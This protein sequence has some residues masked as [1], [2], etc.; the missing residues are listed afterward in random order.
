[1]VEWHA[2]SQQLRRGW[3][4][5]VSFCSLHP[6][7]LGQ[8]RTEHG[9]RLL[10]RRYTFETPSCLTYEVSTACG[11][12]QSAPEQCSTTRPRRGS[13]RPWLHME[14]NT[15]ITHLDS[16]CLSKPGPMQVELHGIG[17][18]D[19]LLLWRDA[20]DGGDALRMVVRPAVE[21]VDNDGNAVT[22]DSD[23]DDVALCRP[24][25]R[26]RSA[27][28]VRPVL[29][30]PSAESPTVTAD[31]IPQPLTSTWDGYVEN[32]CALSCAWSPA[33]VAPH[34]RASLDS[35]PHCP[36]PLRALLRDHRAVFTRIISCPRL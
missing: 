14:L 4:E 17:D 16:W 33:A 24:A 18:G 2:A 25:K 11:T 9:L 31:G 29:A 35:G 7:R 15:S 20:A 13:V 30:A 6:C 34:G 19:R 22:D 8:L 23:S 27:G 28:D 5:V 10:A 21:P 1:M 36:K 3:S 12:Q 26:A 32:G